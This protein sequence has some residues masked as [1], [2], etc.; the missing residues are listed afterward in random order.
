MFESFIISLVANITTSAG[1]EFISRITG[2]SIY[3]KIET[4][5]SKAL[6]KWSNNSGII[7]REQIWTQKRL[8][9]LVLLMSD[10]TKEFNVDKNTLDLLKLFRSEL[11]TDTETWHYLEN[12]FLKKSIDILFDVKRAILSIQQ[13]IAAR[14]IDPIELKNKLIEQTNFQIDKNIASGKYIP[15]TFMEISE[16]K[17]HIRYFSDPALFYDRIY[18]KVA[19]FNFEHLNRQLSNEKKELFEFDTS[20]FSISENIELESFYKQANNL[21]TYL[22]SKHDE[23]YHNKNRGWAHSHKIDRQAT[24]IEYI[25]KQLC[26]ITANAGQGKTNFLCDFANN[27]LVR[28]NIPTLYINGYEIDA[29]SI[30]RSLAHA[31]YPVNTYSF[32]EIIN[33]IKSYCINTK[34]PFVLIID[35]LNENDSPQLLS[36]NLCNLIRELINHKFIK[37]ILTCRTE[38]YAERFIDIDKIFPDQTIRLDHIHAHLNEAQ[39][40][41]LLNNYLSYFEIQ[42]DLSEEIKTE[43]TNNLLLL[44]IFSETYSGANLIFYWGFTQR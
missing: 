1:A 41:R 40:E 37:I 10:P 31:V 29:S 15:D 6:K 22:K 43:L 18:K 20:S 12:E 14:R 26:I 24:N 33:G 39:K 32:A 16:L 19:S 28:R 4:A 38:Y 23:L 42:T 36:T 13:D 3:R 27:V 35:G 34:K 17:D 21:F 30:E 11:L 7:N 44:R 8:D 2:N 5:Y 25:S 9:G